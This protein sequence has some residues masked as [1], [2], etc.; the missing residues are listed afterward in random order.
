MQT[1]VT[2]PK[3]YA[4]SLFLTNRRMSVDDESYSSNEELVF[5]RLNFVLAA[6]MPEFLPNEKA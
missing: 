3:K 5:L 1:Y 2:E 4:E 6:N